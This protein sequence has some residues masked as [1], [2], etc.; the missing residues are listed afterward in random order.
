MK[1][2]GGGE[3]VDL[4]CLLLNEASSGRDDVLNS[5]VAELLDHRV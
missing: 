3:S 2:S 4:S 1:L 5:I